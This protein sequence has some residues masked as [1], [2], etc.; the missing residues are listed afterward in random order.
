MVNFKYIKLSKKNIFLGMFFIVFLLVTLIF[1]FKDFGI[2]EWKIADFWA[3][4]L[5]P[6]K[7]ADKVAVVGVDDDLFTVQKYEWPLEKDIYGEVILYLQEMGAKVITFDIEFSHNFKRCGSSDSL[8]LGM[9]Q[10][11]PEVVIG[12]GFLVQDGLDTTKRFSSRESTIFKQIDTRFSIG[13][14]FIDLGDYSVIG[15]MIP[16]PTLHSAMQSAG[17]F[18]RSKQMVDGVD[19]FMPLLIEQDSLLFTSLAL[20]SV[21]RFIGDSARY[22]KET[23]TIRCGDYNW[24]VDDKCNIAVNFTDS[25]PVYT[26]SDI[27]LSFQAYLKGEKPE[28]GKKELDGKMIFIGYIAQSDGDLG[29]NPVS[30]LND[31]GTNQGGQT[32]MVM[33]HAYTANTLITNHIIKYYGRK[34]AILLSLTVLLVLLILFTFVKQKVLYPILPLLFIAIYYIGF[35]LFNN[36]QFLPVLESLTSFVIFSAGAIFINYYENSK[37]YRYISSLFRTYISPEL[38]EE[39]AKTHTVPKL[40]GETINGTAFFTDIE[41]FS[42]FSESFTPEELISVL[43]EYFTEMTHILKKNNGTLDK[44]IGDAIVAIFGAPYHLDNSAVDACRSA[45]EMQTALAHLREKWSQ[46]EVL[47]PKIGNMHMR[48]GINSGSFIVGHLGSED[49]MNYTMI[50]DDVNLAARLESGAKQYGV[51]TLIGE[52]TYELAKS[53]FIFRKVDRIIVMG[54]SL[55][56]TVF[57]LIAPVDY[58]MEP[59]TLEC[60]QLYEQGLELY[61]NGHFDEAGKYFN[62]SLELEWNQKLSPSLLMIQRCEELINANIDNWDG[63]YKLK[64]K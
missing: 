39:M 36:Y 19:R 13:R 54:R 17:F 15:A 26:M 53:S 21:E 11:S 50:G 63:V 58:E 48:I 20:S 9:V 12:Y 8:F 32:P 28:I 35:I 49:R 31:A 10:T 30:S 1:S 64:S 55:P 18:N 27:L 24:K 22:N 61:F 62:R 7:V 60:I 37:E 38:I 52:S 6:K 3:R 56:V 57:E 41:K 33:L 34:G 14:G 29:V 59:D 42:T 4:S 23:S 40:G 5:Y 46:D 51:Y 45:F 44:F 25:I 2:L 47:A 16:Y 43:N